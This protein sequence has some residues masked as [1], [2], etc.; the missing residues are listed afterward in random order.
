MA[1]KISGMFGNGK[2]YFANSPVVI[3]ISGLEWGTSSAFKVVRVNVMY[4]G[5]VVGNFHADTGGQNAISFDI[6][7]ALRT[8]WSDYDFKAEVTKALTGVSTS[9][10]PYR[11]YSLEVFSEY[12]DSTDGEFTRTSSGV[13]TGGKCAIG[14]LTEWERSNIEHKEDADISSIEGS[15]TR[16]G[17]AST[18]PIGIP[19]R[20]GEKS[21]TSWVDI[22]ADGTRTIFYPAGATPAIDSKNAHSPLVVRDTRPYY[23]F[24]FVN[25]RGA[26]E[27]C[28]ALM[29]EAMNIEVE[30][31]QYSR[32]ERP[33]FQPLRSLMAIA[34]G[35]RRSWSMS[36]G[37]QTRDWVEWWALEFMM[38]HQWWMLYKGRYV[39]VIVEPAKKSTT[40]Y[41]KNKQKMESVEFTVTLAVEG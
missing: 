36:S 15:N 2:T 4:Q 32:V 16:N 3:D 29:K 23:D 14:A 39:P 13:I 9:M 10:R 25:R 11:A 35:G 8:I 18:K 40:I 38:S 27:T 30:T 5:K 12:L 31:K 26:V 24:L 28:S 22:S 20:V 17:D 21:I 7:S 33:T 37:Y 19:E 34:K 1:I 6:S 41:D